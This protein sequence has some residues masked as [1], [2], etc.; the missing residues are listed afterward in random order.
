[1]SLS[2]SDSVPGTS[3]TAASGVPTAAKPQALDLVVT[4]LSPILAGDIAPD[5]T[6]RFLSQSLSG[7]DDGLRNL[8]AFRPSRRFRGCHASMRTLSA[9]SFVG[10][11]GLVEFE[12]MR[13]EM[14]GT[15]AS[16]VIAAAAFLFALFVRPCWSPD[17]NLRR[18]PH[19]PERLERV[20]TA[21]TLT[22]TTF[23]D[24]IAPGFRALLST[25][26]VSNVAQRNFGNLRERLTRDAGPL[27][28]VMQRQS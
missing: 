15:P 25:L 17:G 14:F 1:M 18:P 12:S 28:I 22:G 3:D 27:P 13:D 11:R 24:R 20:R 19:S 10:V 21:S 8:H 9:L 26:E 5:W 7:P 23:I 2:N 6:L 16:P 4:S